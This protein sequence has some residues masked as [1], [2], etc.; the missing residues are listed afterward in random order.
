MGEKEI[1]PP[2]YRLPL[3]LVGLSIIALLSAGLLFIKTVQH[4][5]PIQFSSDGSI[6]DSASQSA[7][8]AIDVSGAVVAPGVYMI[9][10]G[11]RVID[12][13][14]IAGGLTAQADTEAIAATINQA[15][16]LSDGAKVYIPIQGK[17]TQQ[18]EGSSVISSKTI[19]IN[20]ASVSE[21]DTLS[22]VG[23]VTAKKII[24][25][26]PYTNL[27]DLVTKKAM[28]QSLFD[29]LKNQLTL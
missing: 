1:V 5:E 6:I 2:E 28:G 24:D 10:V 25:N 3:F 17:T 19:S 9:S 26:R 12:A 14:T 27:V 29:K 11:S 15:S 22:G 18:T 16:I 21:L 20:T 23:P 7:K 4:T 13:I 8:L